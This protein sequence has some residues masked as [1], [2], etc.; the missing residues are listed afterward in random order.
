MKL[1]W[2]T[3]HPCQPR[4]RSSADYM[5]VYW[6]TDTFLARLTY[7]SVTQDIL[8]NSR[9]TN[10]PVFSV[11]GIL[12]VNPSGLLF[13]ILSNVIFPLGMVP[14]YLFSSTSVKGRFISCSLV[15]FSWVCTEQRLKISGNS[16]PSSVQIVRRLF[17]PLMQMSHHSEDVRRP[18]SVWMMHH[19][20]WCERVC[21][22]E[23]V[24][25]VC[26]ICPKVWIGRSSSVVNLPS[27]IHRALQRSY[28]F[29]SFAFVIFGRQQFDGKL[30]VFTWSI[31]RWSWDR[32]VVFFNHFPILSRFSPLRRYQSIVKVVE[33]SHFWY[34]RKAPSIFILSFFLEVWLVHKRLCFSH[35]NSMSSSSE[36]PLSVRSFPSVGCV[37]CTISPLLFLVF[38]MSQFLPIF[39]GNDSWLY[40]SMTF[41][42]KVSS[43]VWA[44]FCGLSIIFLRTFV[45]VCDGCQIH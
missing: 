13:H 45:S 19:L 41:T 25:H 24:S 35:H 18:N 34:G 23:S 32:T 26:W 30:W 14:V 37:L 11:V 4:V 31:F 12:M 42:N 9:M 1:L 22:S 27:V 20:W 5:D 33:I 38:G 40:W 39:D 15:A 36:I 43:P 10:S 28:L 3:D 29:D 6:S 21:I 7:W 44:L 17:S 8:L 16:S 2:L